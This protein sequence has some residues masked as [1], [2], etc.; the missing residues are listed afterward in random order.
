MVGT[1]LR[2]HIASG[3]NRGNTGRNEKEVETLTAEV[4]EPIVRQSQSPGP[5]ADWVYAEEWHS[6]SHRA[7]VPDGAELYLF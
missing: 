7:R 4:L 2:G 3:I 1:H 5:R 6:H